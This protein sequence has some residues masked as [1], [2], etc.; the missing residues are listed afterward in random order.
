MSNGIGAITNA[1][2]VKGGLNF[3][4]IFDYPPAPQKKSLLLTLIHL[5]NW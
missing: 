3:V 4:E 1:D 2:Q 5:T